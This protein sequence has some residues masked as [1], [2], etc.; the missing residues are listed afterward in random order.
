MTSSPQFSCLCVIAHAHMCRDS[1][2]V[3]QTNVVNSDPDS[4]NVIRLWSGS[5]QPVYGVFTLLMNLHDFVTEPF[6]PEH[7][8][9]DAHPSV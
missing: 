8:F 4:G 1:H 5:P 3:L 2:Q 6:N 9:R 7:I